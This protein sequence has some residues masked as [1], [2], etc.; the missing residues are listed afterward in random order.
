MTVFISYRHSDTDGEARAIY[1][2]VAEQFGADQVFFDVESRHP[3]ADLVEKVRSALARCNRVVV[4]IG[5]TWLT[6]KGPDGVRRVDDPDDV[7]RIEVAAALRD[8]RTKVVPVLVQQASM[9]GRHELPEDIRELSGREAIEV[10]STHWKLDMDRLMEA[11]DGGGNPPPPPTPS[12][13]PL[14]TAIE[15]HWVVEI[16]NSVGQV[17]LMDL[18]IEKGVLG[19]R[20]FH[21]TNKVGPPWSAEGKWEVLPEG[22]VVLDGIQ[23]TPYPFPQQGPYQAYVTFSEVTTNRFVGSTFAG[24]S[25]TWQ[26]TR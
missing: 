18:S 9:P 8:H 17:Q 13:A 16:R 4:V 19:R 15:G 22:Q 2:R 12:S 11:L 24:E 10:S 23:T 3:G 7:V 6:A 26:R 14:R 25:I 21:A 20:R 5:R 1:D